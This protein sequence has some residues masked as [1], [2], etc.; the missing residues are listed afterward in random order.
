MA[1]HGAPHGTGAAAAAGET[2]TLASLHPQVTER[3]SQRQTLW[4]FSRG[5]STVTNHAE[6]PISLQVTGSENL[7][8]GVLIIV[9]AD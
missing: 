9:T 5:H 2:Q 3:T 1:Q 8:L 7:S 4:G 6:R